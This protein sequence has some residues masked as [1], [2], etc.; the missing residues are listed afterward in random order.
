MKFNLRNFLTRYENFIP[1]ILFPLITIPGIK[2]GA[3]EQW[4]PDKITWRV[5]KATAY[6]PKR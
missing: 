1:L 4:H 2:R 6:Q 3:P 5:F